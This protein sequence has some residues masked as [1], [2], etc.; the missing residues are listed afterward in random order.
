M[1]IAGGHLPSDVVGAFF[2]SAFWTALAVAVLRRHQE[3]LQADLLASVLEELATALRR[4]LGDRRHLGC[5]AVI[6]P[7]GDGRRVCPRTRE[8]P[9][10]RAADRDDRA[11][12]GHRVRA[13]ARSRGRG[14]ETHLAFREW[15]PPASTSPPG[16]APPGTRTHSGRT[17]TSPTR[18][19]TPRRPP[20]WSSAQAPRRSRARRVLVVRRLAGERDD[21]PFER[22]D[23]RH[24]NRFG[25]RSWRNQ[26][27]IA[28]CLDQSD[29]ALDPGAARP[30]R[31]RARPG[32]HG[33]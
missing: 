12:G 16:R 7:S 32:V 28:A 3:G 8:V 24:R 26:A 23:E 2:L 31:S 30:A 27:V 10:W 18:N 20:S 22:S 1:V 17:S 21:S 14:R 11:G 4:H 5:A 9:D 25:G 6:A 13:I 19:T 33:R 29:H 15:E